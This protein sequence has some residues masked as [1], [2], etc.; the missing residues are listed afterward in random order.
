MGRKIIS[1]VA[2]AIVCFITLI[3]IGGVSANWIYA[4]YNLQEKEAFVSVGME[5]FKWT[6]AEIFPD[7][8]GNEDHMWLINN[9]VSGKDANGRVIGLDNANSTLSNYIE[10]RLDGGLFVPKRRYFGSMAVRGD[11]EMEQLFGAAAEGLSF[12]IYVVN[13]YEYYIFTTDVYLGEKGETNWAQTSNKT[14]GKPSVPLGE[15][16]YPV[17]RTRIVRDSTRQP[18]NIV[19]TKRG[20][21]ISAWY[22]ESRNNNITQIPSFNPTSWQ[23]EVLGKNMNASEAI[24]TF[25]GDNPV[26][27]SYGLPTYYKL[28]PKTSA[29]IT[30]RI[31]GEG[32]LFIYDQNG[33]QIATG[34]KGTNAEG[35]VVVTATWSAS[36]T[37]YYVM[38]EAPK[39]ILLTIN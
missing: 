17:Y 4:P 39:S 20:Y 32:Y 2:L 21:A 10:D 11:E 22:D 9:L 18:W 25:V 3:C 33:N 35:N 36:T 38:V 7:I 12:I 31:H 13:D 26:A 27:Y 24:V 30:A 16:V 1:K 6:G 5:E 28:T 23:E 14:P 19:E 15:K 34:V 29:I 37:L 8:V